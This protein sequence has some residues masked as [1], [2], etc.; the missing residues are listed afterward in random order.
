M[1]EDLSSWLGRPQLITS[2]ALDVALGQVFNIN[3]NSAFPLSIPI[4]SRKL[5][6]VLGMRADLHITLN[7]NASPFHAGLFRLAFVPAEITSVGLTTVYN[8]TSARQTIITCPGQTFSLQDTTQV[9]FTIP[10]IASQPF[11]SLR[12]TG[13]SYDALGVIQLWSLTGM[14]LPA[15][16][17]SPSYSCYAH[18]SNIQL[19]GPK[20]DSW[21][22]LQPQGLFEDLRK[23]RAISTTMAAGSTILST[24]GAFPLV[25]KAVSNA[26]WLLRMGANFASRLGF[27]KPMLNEATCR[28]QPSNGVFRGQAVG[29]DYA[30]NLSIFSDSAVPIKAVAG[31]NVDESSVAYIASVPGLINS[32]T[33]SS[34]Q[35][36]GTLVYAAALTPASLFYQPSNINLPL[37]EYLTVIR[38]ACKAFYMAPAMGVASCAKFWR[39]D[40]KFIFRFSKTRFHMGR[41]AFVFVPGSHDN[42]FTNVKGLTGYQFP[43]YA[44]TGSLPRTLVD[45]RNVSEAVVDCPFVACSAMSGQ[46]SHIGYLCV[47]VVD[48]VTAPTTVTPQVPVL[49]E[50][51]MNKLAL[52]V[53]VP[54]SMVATNRNLSTE[55]YAQSNYGDL[56]NADTGEAVESLNLLTRRTN[57]TTLP[58]G[59]ITPFLQRLPAYTGTSPTYTAISG[60]GMT[61]TGFVRAAF[62]FERGGMIVETRSLLTPLSAIAQP[63]PEPFFPSGEFES[64][65]G[66]PNW[67][68]YVSIDA[69]N[70]PVARTYVPRYTPN[71]LY[72]A[73][74]STVVA[75][76]VREPGRVPMPCVTVNQGLTGELVTNQF[77]GI[78]TADDHQFLMFIGWPAM[79]MPTTYSELV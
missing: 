45:L 10:Y 4:W 25:P 58:S 12:S 66:H 9:C 50:A 13:A 56:I 79:V 14:T 76:Q 5:A 23:S 73:E 46:Q 44:E 11:M 59:T 41:L 6:N 38:S 65:P 61:L 78:A 33:L 77:L 19:V 40:F 43:T 71:A 70:T 55:M 62:A 48:P 30:T 67:A 68:N 64:I 49:V 28:V 57:F 34:T 31:T 75:A 15:G 17:P 52:S 27:S 35:T 22:A 18:W 7:V 21:S 69:E 60:F 26:G 24:I 42:L 1:D 36:A 54:P 20:P 39:G 29:A 2:G 51:A 16:V 37:K 53:F 47:Y 72:K 63:N 3:Y 74:S 8:R 32:F